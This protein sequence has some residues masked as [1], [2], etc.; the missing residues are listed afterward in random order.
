MDWLVLL[1]KGVFGLV[2]LLAYMLGLIDV[3]AVTSVILFLLAID[4]IQLAYSLKKAEV[5]EG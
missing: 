4:D 5:G 2:C 3:N 1:A